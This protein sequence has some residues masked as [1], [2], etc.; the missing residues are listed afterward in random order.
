[1]AGSTVRHDAR[2]R[3]ACALVFARTGLSSHEKPAVA[4]KAVT[5]P[6]P[7]ISHVSLPRNARSGFTGVSSLHLTVA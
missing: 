6:P 1:M 3:F 5:I 7:A 2:N 4:I